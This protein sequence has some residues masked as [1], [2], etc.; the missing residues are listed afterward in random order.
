M[1]PIHIII[2]G[3]SSVGKSTLVDECL[4]KF[5]QDKR[6]KTI[7]FKH[8]QEV[9]RTVLNRLKITGKHLQDYI[10]QNNIE[11]FSNVQEKII[12]E[13]IVSFDKE[14]DNNYLSD[15]SGFDALAYIHHYFENEQK[16]NSIF[17]K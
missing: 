4:R 5:R 12:Q 11:K 14:K 2:S 13:Q 9:A 15:R 16:A 10:R 7:Q 1:S 8:I 17:S 3:A 6:L